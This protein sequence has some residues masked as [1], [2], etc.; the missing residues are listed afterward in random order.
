MES[1]KLTIIYGYKTG[2]KGQKIFVGEKDFE[3]TMF[4]KAQ[5]SPEIISEIQNSKL[6]QKDFL[7]LFNYH[8]TSL[9]WFM[10]PTFWAQL[11]ESINFLNRF[12]EFVDK[13]NPSSFYIENDFSK[14]YLL[15][16]VCEKRNIKFSCS[17]INFLK[18][19]L[20]RMITPSIRKIRLKKITKS[21]INSRINLYKKK[22]S[23]TSTL[24][25]KIVFASPDVYRR[26]LINLKKGV[27]EEGELFIQ[28]LIDILPHSSSKLGIALDYDIYGNLPKLER[29]LNSDIHW[30]P[31]ELFLRNITNN[32]EQNDFLKKYKNFLQDKKLQALFSYKDISL[33]EQ[34]ESTFYQMTFTPYFPLWM[35]LIDS[36]TLIFKKTKPKAIFLPYETGPL[37][38][39]F[40]VAGKKTNVTTIGIQHGV[41]ADNWKFYSLE[42]LD[43]NHPFGFPLPTKILL[44]GDYSK[45][46]LLKNGYP[47]N[48][49][50]SF[51]NPVFFD[52]LKKEEI[53]QNLDIRKKHKIPKEKTIIL[54]TTLSLQKFKSWSKSNHNTEIWTYLL[55]HYANQ[56]NFF[57]IVKPH[58]DEDPKIYEKIA[59]KF[60]ASNI[61]VT[62][63][64]LYEFVYISNVVL[65]M[66]S[67][68]IIDSL[69][70]KKPV[71]QIEFDD[72]ESPI[73]FSQLGV[74][75]P[76]NLDNLSEKI[77]HVLSH[78]YEKQHLLENSTKFIKDLYNIP[79]HQPDLTLKEIFKN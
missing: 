70:F 40:I 2:K 10:F 6:G 37:A 55:T 57:L 45:R 17:K 59:E 75:I 67:T 77:D 46:I 28:D 19:Q 51:G 66:F 63:Q 38:L 36:L 7:E 42:P 39:C 58:P 14:Y 33:W 76:T 31:V 27:T 12:F 9:Y 5:Y 23:K 50:I 79:E 74:T 22:F 34:L 43:V 18:F 72:V 49:L 20:R 25:Q 24:D 64:S 3:S 61:L 71:I 4:Q 32:K 21:K 35:K 30:I 62:K 16:Q 52:L 73:P 15:K 60:N 11:T 56:Q 48:K 78:D 41:I 65:S 47:S 1:N 13:N 8:G 69:C 68:T 54:F 26:H 29:R 44:F 53:L